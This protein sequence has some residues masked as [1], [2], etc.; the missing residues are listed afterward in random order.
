[1]NTGRVQ[2]SDLSFLTYGIDPDAKIFDAERIFW[3]LIKEFVSNPVEIQETRIRVNLLG[4]QIGS[5]LKEE[6]ILL[7][8]VIILLKLW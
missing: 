5:A 6:T 1:M 8:S 7:I 2:S 3:N 4:Q